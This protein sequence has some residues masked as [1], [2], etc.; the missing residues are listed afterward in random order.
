MVETN[1]KQLGNPFLFLDNEKFL[2]RLESIRTL[3]S[4]KVYYTNPFKLIDNEKFLEA[5]KNQNGNI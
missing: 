2:E 1:Y 4:N 5:L 3:E